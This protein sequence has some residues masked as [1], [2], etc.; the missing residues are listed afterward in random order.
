M[1]SF[2]HDD[3]LLTT[4]A[5]QRLYHEYAA[6]APIIDYHNHLPPADIATNRQF[7]NLYEIWLEG[8]HY[9]WRAMRANG[10]AEPLCTGDADPYEKYMAWAR[11]VPHTLRNP[12]YHW[13]HLELKRYFGIDQLLNEQ[14]APEIWEQTQATLATPQRTTQAILN[15]FRIVAL[16]TTDDP[17]DDLRFHRELADADLTTKVFPTFRPDMALKVDQPETWNA[18]VDQLATIS[19]MHIANL[20]HLTTALRRRHDAFHAL[21]GRL[22]DHGVSYFSTTVCDEGT[23]ARIFDSA[24]V[25][26]AATP[27]EQEQ[28]ASF[29]MVFF[30]RLDAEKGWTKQIHLGPRRNNNSRKLREV[31]P[32][33]G[34]DSIGDWPQVAGLQTYLDHLD[35]QQAL[36]KLVVYNNNPADNFAIATMLGNFQDGVTPGKMQFGSGWWHLD[37]KEGMEWQ[38]NTLS[39]VGLLSR[40]IGM[41]TDSRSFMSFPRH[42][43]FRRVLCNLLGQ[44]MEHGEIPPD[45]AMVGTLVRNIC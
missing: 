10:I 31:G 39:N 1:A 4:P 22:S 32:D 40:F 33:T 42:E 7:H 26:V 35:Q 13:S 24:R 45:D 17:V 27:E 14:T 5:A 8:D 20:D 36:P 3:F 28:F 2:I 34:F 18:W 21:G 12:L 16:C 9:K 11:T 29:L 44:D 37:Q 25:G 6:D 41:L 23:A 19:D 15:E 30:G 43:Y 38:L